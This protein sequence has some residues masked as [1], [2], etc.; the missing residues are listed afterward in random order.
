MTENNLIAV[1]FQIIFNRYEVS[2][3]RRVFVVK[4]EMRNSA[5]DKYFLSQF[6]NLSRVIKVFNP[7]VSAIMRFI[8]LLRKSTDSADQYFNSLK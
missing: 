7:N 5:N 3:N 4:I 2:G 6:L 8:L 1:L